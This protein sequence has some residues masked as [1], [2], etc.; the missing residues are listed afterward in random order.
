MWG[1]RVRFAAAAGAVVIA[2]T[3]FSSGHGSG[4]KSDGGGGG[5]CSSSKK[6]NTSSGSGSGSGSG[7]GSDAG[8]PT[9]RSGKN[10]DEADVTILRCANA[11]GAAP[12]DLPRALLRVVSRTADTREFTI[13]LRF[14]DAG[15]REVERVEVRVTLGSGERAELP[16]A[17][18]RPADAGR[19]AE[20]ELVR[21]RS[22]PAPDPS[23]SPTPP[24]PSPSSG[25]G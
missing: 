13:E 21:V 15:D 24:S 12:A 10:R 16:A 23:G 25:T 1:R 4:S 19:V 2:L 7:G 5:G 8:T 22:V 18:T 3:G 9:P 6:R 11:P 17:L 14:E 20:C